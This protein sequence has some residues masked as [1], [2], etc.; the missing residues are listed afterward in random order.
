[1]KIITAFLACAMAT[2]AFSAPAFAASDYFLKIEGVEGE[3]S[4]VEVLD[5]SW[6]ASNPTVAASD[7]RVAA[8]RDAASGQ[9]SGKR[10]HKP[11]TMTMTMAT[12]DGTDCDDANC[13]RAASG[14]GDGVT[15]T[16]GRPDLAAAASQSEVRDFSLTIPAEM[17]ERSQLCKGKHF[18]KATITGRGMDYQLEDVTV[19]SC[20]AATAPIASAQEKSGEMPGR[21]STNV[22]TPKQTQGATFG[23]KCAAGAACAAPVTITM[24]L[25]GQM[26]HTKSGHVT[27]LK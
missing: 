12:H 24:T 1:M 14:S 2:T 21:I 23:E 20:T 16:S 25:T 22:T 18:A 8:P 5:W 26:R 10:M 17:A 15:G 11:M 19:T 27:L 9:A 4:T 3:A 6:G 13:D 7:E